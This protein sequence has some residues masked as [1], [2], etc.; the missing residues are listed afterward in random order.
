MYQWK[1]TSDFPSPDIQITVEHRFGTYLLPAHMHT[2]IFITIE[3]I[4]C[5]ATCFYFT[6][7]RSPKTALCIRT[8]KPV[9]NC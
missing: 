6:R 3:A 8:Y 9:F 7:E 4:F 1:S 2:R 5:P